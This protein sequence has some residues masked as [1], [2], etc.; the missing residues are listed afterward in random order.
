MAGATIL[1]VQKLEILTVEP[2]SR[3]R[4]QC[5]SPV[6]K[7]GQMVG[8][9]W[10]FKR[11]SKWQNGGSPPSGIFEIRFLTIVA[12]KR[13]IVHHRTKFRKG[14]SNCCGDIKISVI[15][16]I[17][18]SP[19]QISS[20]SVKRLQRYG[21]MPLGFFFEMAVVG[22]YGYSHYDHLVVSIVVQYL[23]EIDV[24]VSMI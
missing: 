17:L 21:D 8:E 10:R 1:D 16:Q 2:G 6:I 20:K 12:V 24:L 3:V 11:F 7:I 15:F 13:P 18:T 9:I 5:A 19:C 22:A 14:R 4:G 23:V